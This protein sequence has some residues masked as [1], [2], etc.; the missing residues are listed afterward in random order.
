VDCVVDAGGGSLWCA[1]DGAAVGSS[2]AEFLVEE[3]LVIVAVRGKAVFLVVRDSVSA[4]CVGVAVCI[5]VV[6]FN[7]TLVSKGCHTVLEVVNE[8]GLARVL[9]EVVADSMVEVVGCLLAVLYP[10]MY[11]TAHSVPFGSRT[12]VSVMHSWH[13]VG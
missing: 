3:V 7:E 12:N 9:A 11:A 6:R 13:A 10:I 8:A 4:V 2:E 5:A 1:A